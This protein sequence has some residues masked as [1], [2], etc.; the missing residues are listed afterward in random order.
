[1]SIA[2]VSQSGNSSS[3]VSIASIASIA[4]RSSI[5]NG[6]LG[7]QMLSPGSCHAGLVHWD[8]GTVGVGHQ[9]VERHGR[10]GRETTKNNLFHNKNI[11]INKW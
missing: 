5:G 11:S 1:M 10:G 4:G 3:S 9:A 6:S 8:H 2:S 7:S